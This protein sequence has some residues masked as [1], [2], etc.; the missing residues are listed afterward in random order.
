MLHTF[1]QKKAKRQK[2]FPSKEKCGSRG[3]NIDLKPKLNFMPNFNG[4]QKLHGIS[5]KYPMP[6]VKYGGGSIMVWG[7]FSSDGPK[8]F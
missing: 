3:Y 1:T 7:Y 8:G 6:I 2:L 4:A 5:Q